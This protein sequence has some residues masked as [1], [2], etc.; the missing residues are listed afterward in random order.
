MPPNPVPAW[1]NVFVLLFFAA[2]L[3]RSVWLP[4]V[5]SKRVGRRFQL[6]KISLEERATFTSNEKKLVLLTQLLGLVGITVFFAAV[7]H[8]FYFFFRSGGNF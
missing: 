2:W 8:M 6:A 3:V 4:W 1:G 5:V 7:V